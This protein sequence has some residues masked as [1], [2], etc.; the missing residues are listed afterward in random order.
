MRVYSLGPQQYCKACSIRC[1]LLLKKRTDTRDY[2]EATRGELNDTLVFGQWTGVCAE[3]RCLE[4]HTQEKITSPSS[5]RSIVS[6][7]TGG[8]L[9]PGGRMGSIADG[10]AVGLLG[11]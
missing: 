8:L 9:A 5:K 7:N 11:F 1:R 4:D 6:G 10:W 2:G 3:T